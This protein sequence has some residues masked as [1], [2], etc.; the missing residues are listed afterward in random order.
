MVASQSGSWCRSLVI[1]GLAAAAMAG[2][3]GPS[4]PSIKVPSFV[5]GGPGRAGQAP[6]SAQVMGE[7]LAKSDLDTPAIR[8][9]ATSAIIRG[10]SYRDRVRDQRGKWALVTVWMDEGERNLLH[11]KVKRDITC[12]RSNGSGIR[13]FKGKFGEGVSNVGVNLRC[14]EC[15]ASGIKEGVVDE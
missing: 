4:M 8:A 12:P 10:Q 11:V 9:A 2:C 13:D 7:Y 1:L 14:P 6:I 15:K 5:G 3:D